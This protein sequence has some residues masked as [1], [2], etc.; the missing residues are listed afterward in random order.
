M[1]YLNCLY[2]QTLLICSDATDLP[3][4]LPNLRE[5]ALLLAKDPVA[6]ARA[7]DRR[8]KL[9][10]R[11]LFGYTSPSER[12]HPQD[13]L[14]IFGRVLGYYGSVEAQKKG[15]LHLHLVLWLLH[16]LLPHDFISKLEQDIDYRK[17]VF[18]WIWD[19][20]KQS[21]PEQVKPFEQQ[22][23]S[24]CMRTSLL[25]LVLAWDTESV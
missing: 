22:Q 1:L 12:V 16:A 19:C 6:S 20:I 13:R 11:Y 18:A 24:I 10:L 4:D 2:F 9:T 23:V 8:V 7:F 25:Y 15:T 21:L 17:R 3:P 14:G 5:R